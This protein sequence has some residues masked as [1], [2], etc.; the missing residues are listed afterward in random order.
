M[1]STHYVDL[2]DAQIRE[3]FRAAL[4]ASL[5]NPVQAL[6]F[7]R[8]VTAQRQAARRRQTWEAKGLHVP[9][10]LIASITGKCN[11]RCKGCYAH[12]QRW[13]SR[14]EMS[15]ERWQELI[16][17]AQEL[18]ISLVMIAGGEPLTR[19]EILDVTRNF[20][21][22]VFPLFTNGTLLDQKLILGIEHQHH[23]IP[24]ISLEGFEFQTDERRGKGVY[25]RL[26]MVFGRLRGSDLFFGVSLTITRCNF[27][28][29]TGEEFFK[30]MHHAGAR[31]FIYVEYAPIDETTAG[32]TL[33]PEQKLELEQRKSDFQRKFGG[34]VIGFPG[35][36]EQYGGCLAAGRGFVHIGPDGSLEPCP[37]AP[38]SDENVRERPLREALQSVF[39]GRIR[40]GHDRLK[41]TSSGCALWAN[42]QWV[43]SLLAQSALQSET[44]RQGSSDSEP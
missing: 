25:D 28:T 6:F 11:L 43:R 1:N 15:I 19:P 35:D 7:G 16:A 27:Q 42:R 32:L 39:L 33:T 18:G 8:T 5:H 23:V 4:K 3:V 38:F 30:T 10:L 9:P 44:W 22:I 36:E 37:F 26:Q 20:S 14:T 31:L 13:A 34:V 2:F 12:G 41:E 21:R 17:E 29:L 24:I 40:D